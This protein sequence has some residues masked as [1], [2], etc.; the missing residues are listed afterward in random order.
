MGSANNS[1]QWG[2]S[3][4]LV[5][6][7]WQKSRMDIRRAGEQSCKH[8]KSTNK[9]SRGRLGKGEAAVWSKWGGD[10][11]RDTANFWSCWIEADYFWKWVA[12]HLAFLNKAATS[13]SHGFVK[14]GSCESVCH[15]FPFNSPASLRLPKTLEKLVGS[16]VSTAMALNIW[17][18]KS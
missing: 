2:R 15:R 9:G 11:R 10:F 4:W 1:M 16:F 8:R 18:A 13:A 3:S 6:R 17:N 5:S 12:K 7:D 14:K